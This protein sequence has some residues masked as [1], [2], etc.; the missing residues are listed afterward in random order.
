MLR[1]WINKI[2]ACREKSEVR[3]DRSRKNNHFM[4]LF[5]KFFDFPFFSFPA[6]ERKLERWSS[7]FVK[8]L[9]CLQLT[10]VVLE[11]AMVIAGYS[12]NLWSRL[13]VPSSLP[14]TVAT[15]FYRHFSSAPSLLPYPF[16]TTI[17]VNVVKVHHRSISSAM[18][19]QSTIVVVIITSVS[20]VRHCR[21]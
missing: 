6:H 18:S 20:G 19:L 21:L 11:W 2:K 7:V 16:V 8:Y 9:W 13:S 14:N 3:Q 12:H 17:I 4:F 5:F 10:L 15:A 1:L